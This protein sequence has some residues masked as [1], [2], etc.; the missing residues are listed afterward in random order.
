MKI[1]NAYKDS[2]VSQ[3]RSEINKSE[4]YL[5]ELIIG[6]RNGMHS[7]EF[8]K[9]ETQVVKRFITEIRSVLD[10][11]SK[12]MGTIVKR[13]ILAMKCDDILEKISLFM[14]TKA[15]HGVIL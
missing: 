9:K 3:L 13:L 1:G 15:V 7:L 14:K 5:D 6:A 8:A 12:I 10:V 2:S 4:Y 11:K